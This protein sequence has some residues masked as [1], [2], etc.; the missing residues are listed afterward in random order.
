MDYQTL[1]TDASTFVQNNPACLVWGVAGLAVIGAVVGVVRS[2]A[3]CS[4]TSYHG[5]RHIV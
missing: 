2:L 3:H 5:S 4:R 1:L